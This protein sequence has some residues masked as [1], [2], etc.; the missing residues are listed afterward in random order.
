[1]TCPA[2]TSL[3]RLKKMVIEKG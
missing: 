2:M 3:Q 1:M